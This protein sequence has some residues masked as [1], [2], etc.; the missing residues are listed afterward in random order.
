M[1]PVGHEEI[2]D[3]LFEIANGHRPNARELGKDKGPAS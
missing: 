2:V 3:K 1:S